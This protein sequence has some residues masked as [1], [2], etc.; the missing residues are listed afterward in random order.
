MPT[1]QV[2]PF[3]I[4]KQLVWEAY[5]RVAANKGAPGVDEADPGRVRVRSE[6]Q[7]LQ[8]LESDELGV[9]LSAPGA[10]GRDPEAAWRWGPFARRADGRRPGRA[11]GGGHA[12][13]GAGGTSVP[14]RLLWLPAEQVALD[15]VGV[16]RQRCWKYDWVIDLDVQKFFD[17]VPWDL[18]VKAVEAVTDTPLGAALCEA[19][20]GRPAA[21]PGRHPC[22]A[23]QGNSAGIGGLADPG[24]PVHALCVRYVDG[25]ELSGL[26]RSSAM[27]TM[28]S[29]TVRAGGRPKQC[30]PRSPSGWRRWACGSTRTRRGSSTARTA[31][32]GGS[33]STPR[34][35]SSG[36]PSG[37]GRRG[38]A[39][40]GVLHLVPACDEH[41]GAQGQ[42]RRAPQHAD[43]SAHHPVAGR[44]G[45]M[46][47]PHRA[48]GGCTTTAGSTGRR[49]IPSSS[50]S[51][52]T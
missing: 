19:V 52:P 9:L 12:S 38:A 2:K 48:P 41:R 24:E 37:H 35:P 3:D 22:R 20:A 47:E 42:E 16:C 10:G 1:S 51:T 31:S 30:L 36:S 40:R 50:A 8:D 39:G 7:P 15:A 4:P 11:D 23:R 26:S 46:A 17:T 18:I 5:R 25:P 49:C 14:P 27:P 43:P 28:P 6:E 29:C 33:T 34:S 21:A 13:G 32:A 45:P 44:P